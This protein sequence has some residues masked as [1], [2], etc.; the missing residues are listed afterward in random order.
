ML[1]TVVSMQANLPM[2]FALR[3]VSG[4]DAWPLKVDMAALIDAQFSAATMLITFGALIGRVS[5]L[6]MMVLALCEAFF[7]AVNKVFFV[8]GMI[9]AEDVGGSM[10]IHMFGAYFGLAVSYALGPV[11]AASLEHAEGDKV[12]DLLAMIG[13]TILWVFWPSFV[14]ATETGVPLNEMQCTSNTILAL[15]ASTTMAFYLSLKLT[16]GKFDPVH[17]ANSTLAGG[18]AIGSSGRLNIGPGGAAIIGAAAGAASVYGYVYSTP[19]LESRFGISDT[20]GV[21]NL[22]G[23]PSLVGGVM[24]ILYVTVDPEADFLVYDTASQ[25]WRQLFGIVATLVISMGSGYGTGKLIK[26]LP[27]SATEGDDYSDHVWWHA[28]YFD[29]K[30]E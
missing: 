9:G 15:L 28:E 12:S 14:G 3:F 30:E 24:S 23:W 2:E 4:D 16:H 29:A 27:G 25:M 6:Q 10:T 22:H 18:V 5:P 11:P 8:L 1:L 13:T 21:G 19:Y 20:C 7:Y 17:I 26:T